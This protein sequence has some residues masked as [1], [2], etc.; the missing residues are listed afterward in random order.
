[1][2]SLHLFS[3]RILPTCTHL[4]CTVRHL[5]TPFMLC[6]SHWCRPPSR[7]AHV[8]MHMAHGAHGAQCR[9]FKQQQ[10]DHSKCL[11]PLPA[12]LD[13][14][15]SSA[16]ISRLSSPTP[17][18]VRLRLQSVVVQPPSAARS[19]ENA[20]RATYANRLPART[21][22]FPACRPKRLAARTAATS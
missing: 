13:Q 15:S 16:S 11:A 4:S 22:T 2:I 3:P 5:T 1:M 6:C 17:S 10:P 21:S 12:V 8:P 7:N 9:I 19:A 14:P 20:N 18:D